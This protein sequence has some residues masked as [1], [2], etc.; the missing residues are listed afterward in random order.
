MAVAALRGH[1][2]E[3]AGWRARVMLARRGAVGMAPK[4]GISDALWLTAVGA[5]FALGI[6]YLTLAL[7]DHRETPPYRPLPPQEVNER[8]FRD[9]DARARLREELGKKPR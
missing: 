7:K 8:M 4:T 6:L 2:P 3:F 5:I 1:W 9:A